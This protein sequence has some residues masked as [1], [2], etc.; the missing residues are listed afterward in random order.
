MDA[1]KSTAVLKLLVL[2]VFAAAWRLIEILPGHPVIT[3]PVGVAGVTR[4]KPAVSGGINQL[5]NAGVLRPLTENRRNRAWEAAGLL[6]LLAR[7]ESGEY[8]EGDEEDEGEP[9]PI[10]AP[11]SRPATGGEQTVTRLPWTD[12][13]LVRLGPGS[14]L[15]PPSDTP[16]VTLRV[17]VALPSVL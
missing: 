7:L 5:V 4:T 2:E 16:E 12:E 1:P 13:V 11:R 3:V 10:S 8:P 17:A 9:P 14:W 6:D 15:S